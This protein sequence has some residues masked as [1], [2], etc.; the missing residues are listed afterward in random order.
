MLLV[1]ALGNSVSDWIVAILFRHFNVG[2]GTLP[3]TSD[4]L[5]GP[6]RAQQLCESWG[7]RPGL[8]SLTNYSFCGCKATLQPTTKCI[9]AHKHTRT[10][11]FTEYTKLKWTHNLNR[12][13]TETWD[14]E[15]TC[16]EQKNGRSIALEEEKLKKKTPLCQHVTWAAALSSAEQSFRQQVPVFRL[17]SRSKAE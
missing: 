10:S 8:P 13:Q 11:E 14:E 16:A 12:Q 15:R 1:R 6:V 4:G 17:Q 3:P 9:H 7:G 2:G 5:P